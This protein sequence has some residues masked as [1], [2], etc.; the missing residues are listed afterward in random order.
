MIFSAGR[1]G[2]SLTTAK[3]PPAA[4]ISAGEPILSA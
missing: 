3:I 4:A 2:A 1:E